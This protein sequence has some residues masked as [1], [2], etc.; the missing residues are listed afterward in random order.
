MIK[1]PRF[2]FSRRNRKSL[3]LGANFVRR[4]AKKMYLE[5]SGP[6]PGT[7]GNCNEDNLDPAGSNR[8]EGS[9][10]AAISKF[11]SRSLKRNQTCTLS[12]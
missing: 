11:V 1:S 10:C 7:E 12:T 8:G 9:V 5:V 6:A 4:N 3:Y 2:S